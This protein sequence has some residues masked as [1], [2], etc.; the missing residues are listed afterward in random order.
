MG[1]RRQPHVPQE[2]YVMS[3]LRGVFICKQGV[4]GRSLAC[5]PNEIRGL[6]IGFRSGS[7][8]HRTR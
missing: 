5:P 1:V 2:A 6:D 7:S 8:E 3:H 4:S